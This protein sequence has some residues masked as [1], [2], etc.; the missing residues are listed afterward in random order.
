MSLQGRTAGEEEGREKTRH[1]KERAGR[2]GAGRGADVQR[3]GPQDDVGAAARG[4]GPA[5]SYY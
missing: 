1:P 5:A 2:G 4:G 3:R